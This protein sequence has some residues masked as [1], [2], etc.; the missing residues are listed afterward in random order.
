MMSEDASPDLEKS[1]VQSNASSC[2]SDTTSS[3]SDPS[4]YTYDHEPFETCKSR[5]LQL[6]QEVLTPSNGELSIERMRG[7]GFNRIIGLSTTKQYILR[8]P[9]FEDRQLTEDLAPLQ[10][11]ASQSI[12]PIPNVVKFDTSKSNALQSPY[13]IMD[14]ISGA[15]LWPTYP[16][17]P[18]SAKSAIARDLGKVY[19]E[20]HSIRS[21]NTGRLTFA[22]SAEQLSYES[23]M[24][25]PLENSATDAMVPYENGPTSRTPLDTIRAIL[26][27]KI[28]LAT[29]MSPEAAGFRIEFYNQFLTIASEMDA[30]GVLDESGYCLSHLDLEPR[31]IMAHSQGISGI[32]DWDNALFAPLLLACAPPMWIWA[33]NDDEDEDERLAGDIPAN[34]ESRELKEVFENAAGSIYLRYAYGAQYRIARTLLRFAIDGIQVAEDFGRIEVLQAEWDKIRDLLR[35]TK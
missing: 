13:I 23:L 6:G 27:H 28:E 18:H 2:K 5:A 8:I 15:S 34:P 16:T 32:L 24:I 25:Q 22:P 7:G 12:I 29:A 10:L 26:E 4:T 9:R 3:H 30:L 11:L 21:V 1:E 19:A 14:R 31:N 20:L 35:T 33:W 17:M